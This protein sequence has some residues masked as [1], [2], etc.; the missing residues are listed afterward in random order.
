M[1]DQD[2]FCRPPESENYSDK[3]YWDARY[4]ETQSKQS[5]DQVY[6]WYLDFQVL[7]PLLL[8]DLTKV[9]AKGFKIMVSGCGNSTFCE[10]ICKLGR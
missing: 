7:R 6:E 2:C 9:N 3:A 5:G 10:D 4:Q 8:E 1:T